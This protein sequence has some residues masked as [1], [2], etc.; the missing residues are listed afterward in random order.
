MRPYGLDHK[1]VGEKLVEA[2]GALFAAMTDEDT[3][4][5]VIRADGEHECWQAWVCH[6][7]SEGCCLTAGQ[8]G[9][10]SV[11]AATSRTTPWDQA[12]VAVAMSSC[13]TQQAVIKTDGELPCLAVNACGLRM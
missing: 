2:Q 1:R 5:A 3:Q 8:A 4:R 9:H 6:A 13:D 7:Q 10:T 12:Q 11:R